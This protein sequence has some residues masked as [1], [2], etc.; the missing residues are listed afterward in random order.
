MFGDQ[1]FEQ[2][3]ADYAKLS[4][5]TAQRTLRFWNVREATASSVRPFEKTQISSAFL[6]VEGLRPAF[7]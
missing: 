7:A 2:I 5:A 1:H 6:D 3:R 4:I